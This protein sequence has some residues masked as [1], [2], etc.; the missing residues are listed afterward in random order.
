MKLEAQCDILKSSVAD[1][2]PSDQIRM[3]LGLLDPDP[4]PSFYHEAKLV[5]KTLIPTVLRLLVVFYDENI[6]PSKSNKRKNF[7]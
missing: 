4:D 5:R 2:E 3:I 6:V 7:F 1:P